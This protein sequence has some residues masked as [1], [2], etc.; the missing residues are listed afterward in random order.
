[1]GKENDHRHLNK[2]SKMER[3]LM[4]KRLPQEGEKDL[5]SL[6]NSKDLRANIKS[7]VERKAELKP[8]KE[9]TNT[10]QFCQVYGAEVATPGPRAGASM[11]LFLAKHDIDKALRGRMLDWMIEVTSSYKFEPKTY[12]ASVALMDRYFRA[13]TARLPITRLHIVG[14]ISMLLATKMNEIYP[15]KIRTVFEKIVHRKIEKRELVE[16]EGR[17]S[18]ALDF[19]LG[20]T[21]FYDLATVRL[22]QHFEGKNEEVLKEIEQLCEY[23]GKF[24]VFNYELYAHYSPQTLS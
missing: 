13:E 21:D 7:Q 18:K 17:I 14:V 4:V 1:M 22:Y 23:I 12:F 19:E 15:L 8:I 2:E 16:M 3:L 24:I 6:R 11:G 20:N 5:R 10:Q 9:V